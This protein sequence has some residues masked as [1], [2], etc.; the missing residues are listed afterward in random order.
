MCFRRCYRASGAETPS[1]PGG[2]SEEFRKK[3]QQREKDRRE[4]GVYASSKDDKNRDK[5]RER[6]RDK[7]RERDRERKSDRGEDQTSHL[8][9]CL[10]PSFSSFH[11]PLLFFSLCFSSFSLPFL[12]HILLMCSF[13]QFSSLDYSV[14][15]NKCKCGLFCYWSRRS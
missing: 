12:Y 8:C 14:H 10:L 1:N 7:N 2:V 13:L 11:F 5:E 9:S 3:H 6:A 15:Y 4:H